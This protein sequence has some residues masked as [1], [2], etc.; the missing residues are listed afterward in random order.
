MYT[1]EQ[2]AQWAEKALAMQA[3]YWYGTCWYRATEDLRK[4]KAKQYLVYFELHVVDLQ[5][6]LPVELLE[7]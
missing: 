5:V 6:A 7:D 3:R 4:R 1:G 2:L